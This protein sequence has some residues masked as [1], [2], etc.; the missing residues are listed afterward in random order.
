MCNEYTAVKGYLSDIPAV[1]NV[2][3]G[4]EVIQVV[5]VDA[6]KWREVQQVN[7]LDRGF[8]CRLSRCFLLGRKLHT[9]KI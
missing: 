9:V 7:L 4:R 8:W 1:D 5:V 3:L 6:S 2:G